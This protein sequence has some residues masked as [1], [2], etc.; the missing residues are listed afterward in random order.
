VSSPLL[1][2]VASLATAILA[3]L[4]R[5]QRTAS[6]FIAASGAA[7]LA[8]FILFVPLDE[9]TSVLGLSLRFD[10][11]WV[12]LGRVLHLGPAIRPMIGFLYL[13]GL[14]LFSGSW[15]V[16]QNR[17]FPSI[18]VLMLMT[19]AGS[20]MV[21]PFLFASAFIGLAAMGSVLLL[22]SQDNP[23]SGGAIRLMVLYTFAML[24][25]LLSGWMIE[26]GSGTGTSS[27]G[28]VSAATVLSFG[29]AILMA[30]PP[31][32][33]WLTSGVQ[34]SNNF[35]VA[36][37]TIILQSAGFFFLLRFLDTYSWLREDPIF[38][39]GLGVISVGTMFLASL[40]AL[41]SK[42]LR[43]VFAYAIVADMGVI[44]L[45]LSRGSSAGAR[46][47]LA[48]FG[49]RIFGIAVLAMGLCVIR[50]RA[51]EW[52]GAGRRQPIAALS[53]LVGLLSLVGFPLTAGFPGR[54]A[55]LS[56]NYSQDLYILITLLSTMILFALLVLRWA[57][58]LFDPTQHEERN[59]RITSLRLYLLFGI[60][61]LMLLGIAP[62][63]LVPWVVEV[64]AGLTHLFP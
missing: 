23:Q 49:A 21:E 52:R 7:L 6:S 53:I 31:F 2:V 24:A 18:A 1:I 58:I 42:D 62:Q 61:S 51:G 48:L 33:I 35:I 11:Q 8:V 25:I 63:I 40:W 43:K 4:F 28:G 30:I 19:V 13:A 22:V 34:E 55:L 26:T 17:F 44:L 45:A 36:F 59:P 60:A 5:N 57:T 41:S 38:H 15:L 46:I 3:G 12:V 29:F 37:V 39:T 32:H 56:L 10:S 14:Y 47:A 64:A 16:V 9:A 27:N 20:I 54:W 50:T